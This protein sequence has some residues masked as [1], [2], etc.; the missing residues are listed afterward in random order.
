MKD[1]CITL[2]VSLLVFYVLYYSLKL[3]EVKS[4][5]LMEGYPN[6]AVDFKFTGYC[7]NAFKSF[8]VK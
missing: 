2:M 4:Q 1:F 7:R 6:Y 8:R 3:A 5:C